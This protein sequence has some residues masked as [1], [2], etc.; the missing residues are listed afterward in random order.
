M[1]FSRKKVVCPGGR[2]GFKNHKIGRSLV[3]FFP[4]WENEDFEFAGCSGEIFPSLFA[5]APP[6]ATESFEFWQISHGDSLLA[7]FRG[8]AARERR[9]VS[10]KPDDRFFAPTATLSAGSRV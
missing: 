10:D 5:L 2:V 9:K 4:I 1:G 3:A 6:Q 7:R 8:G